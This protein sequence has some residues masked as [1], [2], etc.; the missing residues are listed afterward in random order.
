MLYTPHTL[1]VLGYSHPS[2]TVA[3]A[4]FRARHLLALVDPRAPAHL[5]QRAGDPF[6]ASLSLCRGQFFIDIRLCTPSLGSYFAG[7]VG[8]GGLERSSALTRQW[9]RALHHYSRPTTFVLTPAG[10]TRGHGLG[11]GYPARRGEFGPILSLSY[12]P[13]TDARSR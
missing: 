3:S 10:L 2:H 13:G 1:T 7:H 9:P 6:G 11:K 4:A 5:S 8:K 12:F